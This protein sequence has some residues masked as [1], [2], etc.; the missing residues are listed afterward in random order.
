ML[1]RSVLVGRLSVS[2]SDRRLALA[3]L[4]ALVERHFW[5]LLVLS[6]RSVAAEMEMGA[7]IGRELWLWMVM[8][9]GRWC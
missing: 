9:M 1:N 6:L 4:R 5:W 2:R 3:R 8:G 7:W